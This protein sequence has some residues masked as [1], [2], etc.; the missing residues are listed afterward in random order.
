MICALRLSRKYQHG[1]VINLTKTKKKK[2]ILNYTGTTNRVVLENHLST[3]PE[4]I[5]DSLT[6]L[7][8]L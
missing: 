6:G 3:L 8:V 5:F 4:G 2:S 7:E 1:I